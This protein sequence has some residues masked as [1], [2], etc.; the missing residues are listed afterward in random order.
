[1][2]KQLGYYLT[3]GAG[4][5]IAFA[6]LLAGSVRDTFMH[7]VRK[8]D[9][10]RTLIMLEAGLDPD[11]GLSDTSQRTV[12]ELAG[13]KNSSVFKDLVKTTPLMEAAEKG[14]IAVAVVLLR[15][16]ADVNA[17][18]SLG[19]TP[20]MIAAS[21]DRLEMCRLLLDRGAEVNKRDS[22]NETALFYAAAKGHSEIVRLFIQR[23]ADMNSKN[24][25]GRTPLAL[26]SFWGRPETV[27]EILKVG[28]NGNDLIDSSGKTV[29]MNEC[30]NGNADNV[31]IMKR[32]GADFSLSDANGLK[33][34]DYAKGN[35]EILFILDSI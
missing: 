28:G 27:N 19:V 8:D 29:L 26:A 24:S 31:Q 22:F 3:C 2:N 32:K 13:N 12:S 17:C 34:R 20:L 9:F 25:L 6:I 10:K 7:F 30:G 15:R 11:L 35:E 4:V 21:N 5:F 1:M 18:T 14:N 23:S 16:G 33:A